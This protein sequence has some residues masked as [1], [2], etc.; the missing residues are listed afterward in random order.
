MSEADVLVVAFDP[1]GLA[2]ADALAALGVA[3]AATGLLSEEQPAPTAPAVLDAFVRVAELDE[4]TIEELLGAVADVAAPGC[5]VVLTGTSVDPDLLAELAEVAVERGA[6]LA[7]AVGGVAFGVVL[8]ARPDLA[9]TAPA[10][11]GA[12][13]GRPLPEGEEQLEGAREVVA[14]GVATVVLPLG[15]GGAL[16]VRADEALV[17]VPLEEGAA[18]GAFLVAG[19]V[20]GSLRGLELGETAALAVAP[21]A[22]ASV[23]LLR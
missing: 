22:A 3:T 8:A 9:V 12:F 7:F 23:E 16:F 15:G 6:R 17:S 10:E 14:L 13:L 1:S 21:G 5:W 2:I 4:E 18:D 11:L 20:A 19:A